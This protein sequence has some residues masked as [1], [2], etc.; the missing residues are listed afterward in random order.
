MLQAL[1]GERQRTV[2]THVQDTHMHLGCLPHVFPSC[3]RSN[4]VL[5]ESIGKLEVRNSSTFRSPLKYWSTSLGTLSR[6]F[7][8]TRVGSWCECAGTEGCGHI[9]VP[10][11]VSHNSHTDSD[12]DYA[13]PVMHYTIL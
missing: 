3:M 9:R 1:G 6:L 5:T 10:S 13:I 2:T 8:P 11:D 4:A 12:L 7:Q